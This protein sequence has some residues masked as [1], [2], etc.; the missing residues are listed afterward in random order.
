MAEST[1]A[2]PEL[3]LQTAQ[4]TLSWSLRHRGP[5]SALTVNA[6]REV[7][8][9]LERLG[10]LDEA[11]ELR[12]EIATY[13]R[14][15]RGADDESTLGAEGLVGFDLERLGRHAEAVRQ[16]EQVV[17]GRTNTLGRDDTSTL[18]AIEWLGCSQ[19]SLGNL[20]ESRRLL[21]EAVDGYQR[22]A[23]GETEGC[24][25]ATSHLATTLFRLDRVAEAD[26]LRRHVS[27]VRNRTSGPDHRP[28]LEEAEV[29]LELADPGVPETEES[30]LDDGVGP[31]KIELVDLL[32]DRP[33]WRLEPSLTPGVKPLW[34]FVVGAKI[35]L[36][37]AVDGSSISLYVT[38]TDTE[39]VLRDTDELTTWLRTHRPAALQAPTTHPGKSGFRKLF[40]WS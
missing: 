18:L 31:P 2:Q 4:S 17:A 28:R 22:Q 3:A 12:S 40:E 11:L 7:A 24:M 33:G 27:E 23:A 9:I 35:D 19:R 29:R 36:S 8:E 15:Q 6:K 32:G 1:D 5:D 25:K 13:F 14:L 20:E 38:D 39:V 21:Q 34:C 26:E 16:F 10:R 30:S 37:L